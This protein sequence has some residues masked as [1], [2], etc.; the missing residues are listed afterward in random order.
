MSI[1][2]VAIDIRPC[3][4]SIYLI[5]ILDN[6]DQLMNHL[7]HIFFHIHPLSPLHLALLP[8]KPFVVEYPEQGQLL[9][10]Y[11]ESIFTLLMLV[12]L[13]KAIQVG[14]ESDEVLQVQKPISIIIYTLV[15]V[16]GYKAIVK[17]L[18]HQVFDLKLAVALLEKC[19][20]TNV[21]SSI[22]EEST[23]E[24]EAKCV[25]L[26]WLSILVLIPFDISSAIQL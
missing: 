3:N 17:F 25:I 20:D 8:Q 26:L 6:K 16:Y 14:V 9:E 7:I 1:F 15:T 24:M 5:D 22:R 2:P 18:P 4:R 23:G 21:V 10:P 12:I 13:S 19:H 11:M